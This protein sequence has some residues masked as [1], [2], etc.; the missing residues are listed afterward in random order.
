MNNPAASSGVSTK[1]PINFIVASDGVFNPKLRNKSVAIY[2]ILNRQK[3]HRFLV[4]LFFFGSGAGSIYLFY[5]IPSLPI[6]QGINEEAIRTAVPLAWVMII[7]TWIL[8]FFATMA[9]L[10][11]IS[12]M[13][14]SKKWVSY[15]AP[16]FQP[17]LSFGYLQRPCRY[18]PW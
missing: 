18:Q 9:L 15:L 14:D 2:S 12:R 6:L 4:I 10:Q 8:L 16:N 5:Q 11:I 13:L 7:P 1:D 3:M 17:C